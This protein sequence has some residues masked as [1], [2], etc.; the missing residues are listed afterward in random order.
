M[1]V[2][3]VDN[4]TYREFLK[5]FYIPGIPVVF[6]NASKAWKA[7]GLFKPAFLRERFADRKTTVAGN[8]YSMGE[9]LDKI[10]KST[11]ENPAP[12]PIKFDIDSQ[13]PE[14]K[15]YIKPLGLGYARPNWFQSR[16]FPSVVIGSSTEL[17]LGS[18]GGKLTTL[19][20][21]YYHTNAWV[22]QLHGNKNFHLFPRGQDDYL[23]PK[24]ENGFES[25]VNIFEPNYDKFPKYRKATPITVTVE[26][27]ET[28]FVPAGIWHTASCLSASISV[29]FDQINARNF[30][31]YVKDVWQEKKR[32]NYARAVAI[33]AYLQTIKTVLLLGDFLKLNP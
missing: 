15:E 26:E 30:S 10:E 12:Y 13:L 6:R 8:A 1:Q 25:Q 7:R 11:P 21:D 29:I 2:E 27:N 20:I 33:L 4:I 18:P 19:H 16:L 9:L 3:K 31:Q 17:F 24:P 28:I 14:L 32:T 23:Y 22:T 5:R